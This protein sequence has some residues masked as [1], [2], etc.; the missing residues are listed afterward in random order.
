[1][2]GYIFNKRSNINYDD[3]KGTKYLQEIQ[4]TKQNRGRIWDIEVKG[5]ENTIKKKNS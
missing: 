5:K 2:N 3:I 4:D 1:M